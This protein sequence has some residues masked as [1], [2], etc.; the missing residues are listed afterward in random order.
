MV[1]MQLS[2][3]LGVF[4]LLIIGAGL[5]VIG[6]TALQYLVDKWWLFGEERADLAREALLGTIDAPTLVS[7]ANTEL[8]FAYLALIVITVGGAFLPA[9]YLVNRRFD[10]FADQRFGQNRTAPYLIAIRQAMSIGILVSFCVWLQMNRMLGV[11][12]VLLVTAVLLMFELLLQIQ[13]RTPT[14]QLSEES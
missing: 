14:M 7:A 11:A 4:P 8:I 9:A 5:T 1:P 10:H 13:G 12:V 2:K 3:R 6:L